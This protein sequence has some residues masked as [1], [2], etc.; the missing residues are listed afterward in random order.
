MVVFKFTVLKDWGV[1]QPWHCSN[2]AKCPVS[3][4]LFQSPLFVFWQI[5]CPHKRLGTQT[6]S[7]PFLPLKNARAGAGVG[8][9]IILSRVIWERENYR[10]AQ[11]AHPTLFS[12][13]LSAKD[14]FKF[15]VMIS[16]GGFQN[17]DLFLPYVRLK[18]SNIICEINANCSLGKPSAKFQTLLAFPELLECV[19]WGLLKQREFLTTKNYFFLHL[20]SS[21]RQNKASYIFSN[22]RKL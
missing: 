4:P 18:Q 9:S 8:G 13:F 6:G 7:A 22:F 20:N 1:A 17:S 15:T 21:W 16:W 5:T 19:Y 10:G 11:P 2:F 14:V 12:L 3:A